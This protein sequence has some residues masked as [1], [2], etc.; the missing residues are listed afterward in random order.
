MNESDSVSSPL[1]HFALLCMFFCFNFLLPLLLSDYMV[2]K[3]ADVTGI[4]GSGKENKR[5]KIYILLQV[6]LEHLGF[7]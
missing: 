3:Q 2:V 1:L 6:G 5:K 7:F 4:I